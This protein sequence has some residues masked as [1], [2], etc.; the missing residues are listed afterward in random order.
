MRLR[1]VDGFFGLCGVSKI[2]ATQFKPVGGRL[3][4]GRSVIYP[5]NLC[6]VSQ[7]RSNNDPTERT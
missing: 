5:G 4:R 2:N 6:A 3:N 1:C 7:C